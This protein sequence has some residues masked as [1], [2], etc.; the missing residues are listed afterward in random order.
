MDINDKKLFIY[1]N[2]NNIKNHNDIINYIE[3]N[4]I[5]Y[6]INDNGF[7]VNISYLNEEQLDF[8]Y[9]ILLYCMKNNDDN[10]LFIDKR[11]E[12]LNLSNNYEKNVVKI[13]QNIPLDLFTYEEQSIIQ[14]SKKFK[15]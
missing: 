8:I 4:D 6:S 15:I 14:Q 13:V 3:S 7:F 11:E 1:K 12:I 10:Q 9:N 2:I 5:K